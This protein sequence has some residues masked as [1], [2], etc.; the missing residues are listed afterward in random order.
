MCFKIVVAYKKG[1]SIYDFRINSIVFNDEILVI[2]LPVIEDS[3]E[4][5]CLVYVSRVFRLMC[6][7]HAQGYESLRVFSE[8]EW[9]TH[10]RLFIMKQITGP[11]LACVSKNILS[12]IDDV[13]TIAPSFQ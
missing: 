5:L 3:K 6:A 11:A 1:N 4:P 2:S 13:R 9:P 10:N 7:L 12:F 8:M